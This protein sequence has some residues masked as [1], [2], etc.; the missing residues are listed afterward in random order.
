M[1]GDSARV[2]ARDSNSCLPGTINSLLICGKKRTRSFKI[3]TKI[4]AAG[5]QLLVLW[6]ALFGAS[7]CVRADDAATFKVGDITFSRPDKWE[8]VPVTGMRAAQLK[9]T[10]A[11]GKTSAD[12]VFF[13]FGPGGAGGRQ[14]NVDRW[15]GQFVE[16]RDQ[17]KS[18]VE[19]VTVGRTR[20]TYVSAEG[21]YKS[22]M[23]GGPS[24]PMADYAL[25]GAMVGNEGDNVIFIKM[26]GPKAL[27]KSA[28]DDFK[29]MV[30][31]GL[32]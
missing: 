18:K 5:F 8:S 32:K 19:D 31:S 1:V 30:E 16:P 28:T 23:P 24:T 15:L 25:M 22:G 7:V 17:I 14:A 2:E 11:D 13:Q 4:K 6:V 21:T 27:V 26:T 12:V 3:K 29:K 10:D 20:V 9:V